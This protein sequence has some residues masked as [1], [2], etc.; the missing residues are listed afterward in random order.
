MTRKN[1]CVCLPDWAL[2]KEIGVSEDELTKAVDE[3]IRI[4]YIQR[5]R[6]PKCGGSAFK[7]PLRGSERERAFLSVLPG[8][9]KV[10]S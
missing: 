2:A 6:C 8:R 3:L 7:F 1:D 5:T 10:Q 4:G 9:D